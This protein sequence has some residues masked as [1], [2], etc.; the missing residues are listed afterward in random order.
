MRDFRRLGGGRRRRSRALVVATNRTTEN[1]LRQDQ[2]AHATLAGA[3]LDAVV[4]MDFFSS[5]AG[6]LCGVAEAVRLLSAV[7]VTGDEAWALP[8]GA[9]M[10]RC[11]AK[12]AHGD[13]FAAMRLAVIEKFLAQ[14]AIK[15]RQIHVE[16]CQFRC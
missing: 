4:A 14:Q 16:C 2:R 5:H 10:D 11:R 1:Q 3:R 9:A 15:S 12:D 7:L 6:V 13:K 8:E